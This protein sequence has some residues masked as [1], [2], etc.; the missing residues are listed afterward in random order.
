MLSNKENEVRLIIETRLSGS[1]LDEALLFHISVERKLE[2]VKF[3]FQNIETILPDFDQITSLTY[4]YSAGEDVP[5]EKLTNLESTIIKVS[6]FIDA[7][8][9]SGKSTLD[10]FAHEIRS[11]YGF[12]G[13]SG[14]LY[15]ENA[16]DL[17]NSYHCDSE[18]NLY[19][20]SNNIINKKWF[21]EL[22]S[23]RKASAHESIIPF[24]ISFDLD[25]LTAQWKNIILKLPLDPTQR[26][27]QYNGKN[28]IE[29][30]K[31]ITDELNKLIVES[32]EKILNDIN[33]G[34]T[35]ISVSC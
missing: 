14:N 7:F 18:L 3:W 8:F 13:H 35:A 15:F 17:L 1:Q 24:R 27:F 29:T 30:G 5:T 2:S 23:Y 22:R 21:L 12:G 31:L 10:A 16:L 26:P 11:I 32:Y 9:M 6:A 20:S 33:Q 28:F 25:T 4:T 19:L 34:K